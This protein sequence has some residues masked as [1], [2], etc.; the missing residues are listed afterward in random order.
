MVKYFYM[1]FLIQLIML[2]TQT[3]IPY[4]IISVKVWIS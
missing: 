2:K 4:G 3:S 1:Y